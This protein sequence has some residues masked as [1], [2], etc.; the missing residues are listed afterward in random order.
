MKLRGRS[1]KPPAVTLSFGEW[2]ALGAIG[3]A[4]VAVCHPAWRGVRVATYSFNVPVIETADPGPIAKEIVGFVADAGTKT[5]VVHGFP[6]GSD[7][8]IHEA[9]A[10]GLSTGCV[11]HSS[12]TQHGAEAGEAAVVDDVLDLVRQGALDRVGFVKE[13]LAESFS[14][15]GYPAWYVPNRI[16]M[17]PEM[18]P[19][20]LGGSYLDIGVFAEPFWRKNVVTQLGAVALMPEARAHVVRKPDVRYLSGLEIV[21]HGELP[22]D[23]F[24]RLEAS[25]DLNLY[26]TLSEC[27]PM[28]PLESYAAGVPCLTSR[29]SVLFRDDP[30]LWELTTLDEVDNP[31]VIAAA[32][33]RLLEH[34]DQAVGAARAWMERWDPVAAERWEQFVS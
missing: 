18:Q 5:L 22:W 24:V 7:R 12:M 1:E 8:L 20:D 28:T 6:P 23:E 10:A 19:V 11:L 30:S 26:A 17:L 3:S 31:R 25:V 34:K 21:E 15:L 16:P 29:S 13:G 4:V 27:H 9:S 2:D 32:A 33:G 14:A